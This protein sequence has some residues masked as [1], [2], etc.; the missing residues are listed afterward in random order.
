MTQKE[1]DNE[2]LKESVKSQENSLEQKKNDLE[3]LT[4]KEQNI[5]EDEKKNQ[6]FQI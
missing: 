2:K 5:A 4:Q 3:T 6:K 1:H